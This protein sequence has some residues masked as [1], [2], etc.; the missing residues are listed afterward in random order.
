MSE[1]IGF[2]NYGDGGK[3]DG[4]IYGVMVGIV[5]KNDSANDGE[6][7]GPGRVKVKIPLLGMKESNWAR[8]ASF[9]AG[10]ERGAFFLP[11]IDDEVLVAFEN[12][13][14]NR[15][16]VIGA[17]WN[18]KD[19]P[20]DINSDGKNNIRMIKSRSGHVLKFND[21]QDEESVTLTTAK[22]HVIRLDDKKGEETVQI[23]DKSGKNKIV[24]QTKDNK[25]AITSEKDIEI[26]A[27]KGKLSIQAKDIEL[28]SSAA[29]KIESSAGMDIKASGTMN[30]KGA[31][32][33]IN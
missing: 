28:K 5:I 24:I 2:S 14:V 12:G 6:K 11:E 3:Y 30:V 19:A 27:P 10:K 4:K 17:L 8:L 32:V 18:G 33:N 21:K 25:I 15:P 16:Y 13:D 26:A 23:I 20:P 31:T 29:T 7:P 9:M 22:G 1:G